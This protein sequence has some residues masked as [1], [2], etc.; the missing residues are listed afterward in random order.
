METRLSAGMANSETLFYFYLP[1]SGQS[2]TKENK[3]EQKRQKRKG[4]EKKGSSLLL[5]FCFF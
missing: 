4:K 2:P 5:T 1:A 3:R